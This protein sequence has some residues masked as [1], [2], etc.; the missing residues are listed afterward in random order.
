MEIEVASTS[1]SEIGASAVGA[2][3]NA[4]GAYSS[5]VGTEAAAPCGMCRQALLE[6]ESKQDNPIRVLLKGG[7]ETVFAIG[8]IKEL[9]P[10]P[11]Y[12]KNLK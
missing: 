10:L 6:Q 5:A 2:G 4:S 11:F 8:S 9:M 3:A 1:A 7:G 12:S